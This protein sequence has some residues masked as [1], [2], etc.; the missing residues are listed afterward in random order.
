MIHVYFTHGTGFGAFVVRVDTQRPGQPWEDVP[1]HC[2]IILSPD[3]SPEPGNPLGVVYEM[4]STGWHT[5][6]A[7]KKDF[8]W[9]VEMPGLDEAKARSFAVS[10]QRARYCWLTILLIAAARCVPD[11]WFSCTMQMQKNICSAFAKT[12]LEA[13]RWKC[14]RW[15]AQ[16][17]APESPN[18]LWWALRPRVH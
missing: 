2:G 7:T 18:D 9:S 8:A 13:S 14:P 6:A 17:Y 5:R 12:V 1:A 10:S 4:I 15:L 3:I 16:Q 11:R